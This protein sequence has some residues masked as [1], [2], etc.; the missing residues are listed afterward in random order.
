MLIFECLFIRFI[1]IVYILYNF[2]IEK[3]NSGGV[4]LGMDIK[5][6]IVWEGSL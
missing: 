2:V 3:F 4:S 1:W 6:K 5:Y